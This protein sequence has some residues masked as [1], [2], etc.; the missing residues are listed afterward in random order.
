MEFNMKHAIDKTN[1]S[2]TLSPEC[3]ED[4]VLLYH[5]M[6]CSD[7]S[8]FTEYLEYSDKITDS[9]PMTTDLGVNSNQIDTFPILTA[10][11]EQIKNDEYSY[12]TV[13]RGESGKQSSLYTDSLI[14][15]NRDR[16]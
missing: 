2:I 3:H 4:R 7:L 16:S 9:E 6:N 14:G 12:H 13:N 11:R 8:K 15:F 5:L 10:T 1:G